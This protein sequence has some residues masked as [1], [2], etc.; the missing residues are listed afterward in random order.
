MASKYTNKEAS[1]GMSQKEWVERYL[2]GAVD[3]NEF[4]NVL[5]VSKVKITNSVGIETFI[6]VE[7]AGL[8]FTNLHEQTEEGKNTTATVTGIPKTFVDLKEGMYAWANVKTHS[9]VKNGDIILP[10]GIPQSADGQNAEIVLNEFGAKWIMKNNGCIAHNEKHVANAYM[11]ILQSIVFQLSDDKVSADKFNELFEYFW[12]VAKIAHY[13]FKTH[14]KAFGII[15]ALFLDDS[16]TDMLQRAIALEMY[17]CI[18]TGEEFPSVYEIQDRRL[19]ILETAIRRSNKH[20]KDKNWLNVK[21]TGIYGLMFVVPKLSIILNTKTDDTETMNVIKKEITEEYLKA[22]TEETLKCVENKKNPDQV[23]SAITHYLINHIGIKTDFNTSKGFYQYAKSKGTK[24]RYEDMGLIPKVEAPFQLGYIGLTHRNQPMNST[25]IR[26]IIKNDQINANK[27]D[28][29]TND[30][31]V[32]FVV[33]ETGDPKNWAAVTVPNG[34]YRVK[35][36]LC[37]GADA[38]TGNMAGKNAQANL[39]FTAGKEVFPKTTEGKST[40]GVHYK[41]KGANAYGAGGAWV[42][43]N[44]NSLDTDHPFILIVEDKKL[45]VKTIKGDVFFK[46]SKNENEP[47]LIGFVYYVLRFEKLEKQP[48]VEP[49]K[50]QVPSSLAAAMNRLNLSVSNSN[51]K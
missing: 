48:E 6:P 51:K 41:Q 5:S 10:L 34:I 28:E 1:T 17:L 44:G 32:K 33:A 43:E 2:V 22:F 30:N 11:S 35:A 16:A 21:P 26:V 29:K 50:Q 20:A 42:Y 19:H 45:S 37:G 7:H 13:Y 38:A 24:I 31:I 15:E 49:A 3:K 12:F 39:R 18:F 25:R 46:M 14:P 47:C 9:I 23:N 4:I 36:I 40:A 27:K 8:C